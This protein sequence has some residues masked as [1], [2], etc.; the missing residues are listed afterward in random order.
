[1]NEQS[2]ISAST[3]A[4]STWSYIK[5]ELWVKEADFN[6]V[7]EAVNDIGLRADKSVLRML[8]KEWNSTSKA[9]RRGSGMWW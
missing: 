8:H 1:M 2:K 7:F 9:F 6:D 5:L 3:T 4:T